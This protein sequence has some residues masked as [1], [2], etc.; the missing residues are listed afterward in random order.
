MVPGTW[1]VV[2]KTTDTPNPDKYRG[3]CSCFS[4][5]ANLYQAYRVIPG[6][7]SETMLYLGLLP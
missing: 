5:D 6:A 4:V 1:Y 7:T 3:L 2:F